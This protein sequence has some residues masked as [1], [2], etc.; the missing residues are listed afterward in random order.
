TRWGRP[1]YRPSRRTSSTGASPASW[2]AA[3]RVA[4]RRREPGSTP[5]GP[6]RLPHRP[7]RPRALPAQGAPLSRRP[8][9]HGPRGP[10]RARGAA[11]RSAAVVGAT[12][13]TIGIL[14]TLAA[15]HLDSDQLTDDPRYD[16]LNR[17]MVRARGEPF[18]LDIAAPGDSEHLV[19]DVDSI[20]PEAACTSL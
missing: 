7:V 12:P 8:A 9:A 20:A 19:L 17:Q 2:W 10:L 11:R 6:G 4:A 13:V 5:D 16:L 14:P 3:H 18:H 1:P 15:E